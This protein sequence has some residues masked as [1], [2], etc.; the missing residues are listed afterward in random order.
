MNLLFQGNRMFKFIKK[1]NGFSLVELLVASGLA[2]VVLL[3]A[4]SF[5]SRYKRDNKKVTEEI[6]ETI[7]LTQFEQVLSKDLSLAKFSLGSLELMDDN[8]RNFFDFYFDVTCEENCQRE[9]VLKTPSGVGSF[10]RPIYFLIQDPFF[11]KEVI[12]NPSEAYNSSTEFQSLNFNNNL[13][14]KLYQ[15]SL[16]DEQQDIIWRKGALIYAYANLPVRKDSSEPGKNAPTKYNYLGW[17]KSK[18]ASKLEKEDIE[19][20]LFINWDVRSM[21]YYNSEDDFL[22]NIPFVYGLANSVYVA[23]ARIIRYRLKAYKDNDQVLGRLYRGVKR[24]DGTYRE[25]VIG[26]GFKELSFSRKDVSLP[27]INVRFDVVEN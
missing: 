9:F 18:G 24:S 21:N 22:R 3:S 4:T 25:F 7:N 12:L 15:P 13:N 26:D 27:F 10:S 19:P 5:F 14:N 1:S 2:G 23:R 11:S 6:L 20:D 17:V 16:P 8:D